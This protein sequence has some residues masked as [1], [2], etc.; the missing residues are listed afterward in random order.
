MFSIHS[1]N[2]QVVLEVGEDLNEMLQTLSYLDNRL[3]TKKVSSTELYA[4]TDG[5][6]QCIVY[7]VCTGDLICTWSLFSSPA[8]CDPGA[9]TS[10]GGARRNTFSSFHPW[11]LH[12]YPDHSWL[13][14]CSPVYCV[15]VHKMGNFGSH[16]HNWPFHPH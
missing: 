2:N 15:Y 12:T 7:G 4:H 9:Y 5:P 8:S 13:D 14:C 6:V 11:T 1:Q 16:E 3:L 10:A